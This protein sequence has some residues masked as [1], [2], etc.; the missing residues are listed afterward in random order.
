MT[1]ASITA[2]ALVY[3]LGLS[4]G[5]WAV[6][7]AIVVTQSSV[8]G[9]LKAAF[10]QLVGSLFGAVYGTTIALVVSPDD[11]LSS[12][13]A[14]VVALAPLSILAAF[15]VGFRIAPITAAIMLLG[16]SGFGV[17]PLGLAAHRIIG[18]SLGCVVGLLVSVFVVPAQAS[19]SVLT[20]S[21]QVAHLMAQQLEALGSGS[22]T[23][24][25]NLGSLAV[26]T[27]KTLS[28]LETLVE[29]AAHER[30]SWLTDAPDGEPLL[31]TMRRLRHDVGML[32]RAAREAGQDA[33]HEHVAKHWLCA[34]QTG[35]A[36]LRRVGQVLAGQQAPD[37]SNSLAQ[38]V[39]AYRVAV[40]EMR[41]A[42]MTRSLSTAALGRLFGIGFA[43]DQF[44]RDLDDLIE[45]SR[46]I[47]VS[48]ARPE[49]IR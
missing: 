40:D 36:T 34:A 14:L 23:G 39:R 24:R 17:G 44:R 31:R 20:T 48:R 6:I 18:V 45:R 10:D 4:E 12:I 30:R 25:T 22:N 9:S 26:R 41:Q 49:K 2:F 35:A 15:S 37:D 21:S 38:A 7:A 19:R 16:G 5:L 32:R 13:G 8:G 46:E 43:L 11:P 28:R 1:A 42:G 47:F 27:R 3:V 33:L 29:E